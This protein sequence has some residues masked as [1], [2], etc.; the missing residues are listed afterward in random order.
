M[1]ELLDRL[2][3]LPAEFTPWGSLRKTVLEEIVRVVGDAPI[4]HSVETGTGKSTLVLSHLS[5]SHTVFSLSSFEQM[6]HV[7]GSEL[8]KKDVV[9]FVEGPTQKTLP[10]HVFSEPIQLAFLDGPHAYP[11]PELE[12][13]FIYPH[14]APGAIL[15]IDD[16]HIP[17]INNLFCFL[18]EDEMFRLESV[19]E[20]TAF[21]R[22][23]SAA[24]F[25]PFGDNWEGQRFN[26]RHLPAL[27]GLPLGRYLKTWIKERLPASIRNR[28]RVV[29]LKD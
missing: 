13:F 9:R 23:T 20:T 14:L 21:F 28:Y 24:T 18:R 6:A 5:R 25:D 22:R 26:T 29:P 1:K 3:A 4:Q 16:I 11:F 8:L 17:T 10:R 27:A 7:Q 2:D 19:V 12:Y 15:V